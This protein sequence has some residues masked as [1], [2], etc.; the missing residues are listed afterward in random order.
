MAGGS[1]ISRPYFAAIST[2]NL[3]WKKSLKYWAR[4]IEPII[5]YFQTKFFSGAFAYNL[6]KPFIKIAIWR[7]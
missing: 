4:F 5:V 3:A 2:K 1:L 6:V 7:G